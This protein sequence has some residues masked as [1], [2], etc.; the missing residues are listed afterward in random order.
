MLEY[1]KVKVTA[2]PSAGAI[3][4][5]FLDRAEYDEVL[6]VPDGLTN[7]DIFRLSKLFLGKV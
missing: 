5:D 2:I 3:K 4:A 7:L 6:V 1:E